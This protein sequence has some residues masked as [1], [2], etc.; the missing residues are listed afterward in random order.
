MD[1]CIYKYQRLPG[2]S[3][4]LE[5]KFWTIH[6]V[7]LP[8]HH[9]SLPIKIQNNCLRFL[10]ILRW[11][12]KACGFFRSLCSCLHNVYIQYHVEWYWI[13]PF[14]HFYARVHAHAHIHTHSLK[15]FINSEC[16]VQEDR[17]GV[18]HI[19]KAHNIKW[20]LKYNRFLKLSFSL[21]TSMESLWTNFTTLTLSNSPFCSSLS[22]FSPFAYVKYSPTSLSKKKVSLYFKQNNFALLWKSYLQTTYSLEC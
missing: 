6:S 10:L 7:L 4:A 2:L 17:V 5:I 12:L 1:F 8:P 11:G 9:N 15:V 22:P 21:P 13:S 14:F 19:K 18:K 16:G 20:F 3:M